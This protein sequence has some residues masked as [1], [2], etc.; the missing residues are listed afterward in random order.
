[1]SLY[2]TDCREDLFF[3]FITLIYCSDNTGTNFILL[4]ILY[5][6]KLLSWSAM[7]LT[8]RLS[9]FVWFQAGPNPAYYSKCTVK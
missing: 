6:P 2:S 8:P 7:I 1:M 3:L 5:P 4:V 9:C